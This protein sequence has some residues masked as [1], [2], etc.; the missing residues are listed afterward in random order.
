MLPCLSLNKVFFSLRVSAKR[1]DPLG[2]RSVPSVSA[3]HA[4]GLRF[5]VALVSPQLPPKSHRNGQ[6]RRHLLRYQYHAGTMAKGR[7]GWYLGDKEG[8]KMPTC[9]IVSHSVLCLCGQRH[10]DGG[11]LW[12]TVWIIWSHGPAKSL[13]LLCICSLVPLP[14]RHTE[15]DSRTPCL[16]T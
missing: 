6:G 15:L 11:K 1:R 14:P 16:D 12:L 7:G 8:R 9:F 3:K 10:F 5:A 13:Q 4:I 2:C